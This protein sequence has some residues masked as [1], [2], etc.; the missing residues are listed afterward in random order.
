[1]DQIT[2]GKVLHLGTYN[3]NPLCMAA[4]KAVL[5]EVCTP[6][7]T[8]GHDRLQPAAARSPARRRSTRPACRRTRCSSAPRAASRG[9]P[10]PIR[11]YRDYKATDFDLA[12][13]QWIHGINRGVLL[14]PGLD[15]QWLDLGDAH[16]GRRDALRRR[17]RG[18]RGGVDRLTCRRH[19]RRHGRRIGSPPAGDTGANTAQLPD[20]DRSRRAAPVPTVR[21]SGS[22]VPSWGR[23][24]DRCHTCGFA[25]SRNTAGS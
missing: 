9:R 24:D 10:T 21:R 19:R 7:A 14:P 18:V 2:S 25:W 4:A 12:F 3:G 22:V 8:A 15:E 5:G 16:R 1:M 11:N 6:E 17:V 23:K 20:D 13:A